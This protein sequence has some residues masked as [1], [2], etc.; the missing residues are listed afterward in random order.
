MK[1]DHSTY[2]KK[3]FTGLAGRYD[4][5]NR[6]MTWGQDKHWKREVIDRVQLPPGGKILDIGAGTGDIALEAFHRDDEALV[7]P[8]DFAPEMMRVGR[9]R[10]E[11]SSLRWVIS[12]AQYLPFR[13]GSLDGVVSSYLLRNVNDVQIVLSEQF[14]VLK[15]GGRIVCLDTTPPPRDLWHLPVHLYLRFV[16][17]LIGG[18]VAG[19]RA[20]YRYLWDSTE[21]FLPA[22]ELAESIRKAGFRDVSY[23][24]FMGGS[25]A[26]HWGIK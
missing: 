15:P 21:N 13:S 5:A 17:P 10:H 2:V 4:L 7:V 9:L 20:A 25:V 26:I 19:D 23:R 14:R 1:P 22:R 6:W 12:D 24:R 3:L 8:A 11:T 16:I 18:W